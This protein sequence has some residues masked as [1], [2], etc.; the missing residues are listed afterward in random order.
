LNG[1]SVFHIHGGFIPEFY[2]ISRLLEKSGIPYVLTTHGSLNPVALEKSRYIKRVYLRLFEKRVLKNAR[3][4][5]FVGK[6]EFESAKGIVES[7][8]VL[9]PNGQDEFQG[10]DIRSLAPKDSIPVFGFLGRIT[11]HTK[12]LDILLAGF[13]R[14]KEEMLGNGKLWIV[15]EGPDSDRLKKLASDLSLEKDITFWGA[16]FDKEKNETLAGM[17]AFFHTSRNEGLPGAVLEAASMGI[18]CI[19]SWETNVGDYI[20]NADA[21]LVLAQNNEMEVARSMSEIQRMKSDQSI[22]T[23]GQNAKKMIESE[24]SWNKIASDFSTLYFS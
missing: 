1:K 2:S 20:K 4:L 12:G 15:G 23:F 11:M 8:K 14:Y 21:G 17:D 18:P 10:P 22:Q 9:I 6:S 7:E 5:H 16:R 13:K 24:F 19:V 3:F